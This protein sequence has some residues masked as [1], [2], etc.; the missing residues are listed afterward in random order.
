[1]FLEFTHAKAYCRI[2][3]LMSMPIE[4]SVKRLWWQFQIML[5]KKLEYEPIF[6]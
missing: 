3:D 2:S 1:M 4:I 6:Q 5:R